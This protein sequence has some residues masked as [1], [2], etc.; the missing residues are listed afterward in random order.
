M[1]HIVSN[2]ST[3]GIMRIVPISFTDEQLLFLDE[4]AHREKM[5]RA[6]TVRHIVDQQRNVGSA[7]V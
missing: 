4:I 3:I 2:M 1:K 6:E 5:S 7:V